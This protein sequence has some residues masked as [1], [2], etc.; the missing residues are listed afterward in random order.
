MQA[1][2]YSR[3]H[4]SELDIDG[5]ELLPSDHDSP[6]M[7]HSILIS[8]PQL[9]SLSYY[10]QRPASSSNL[11][12]SLKDFYRSA[13]STS[14]DSFGPCRRIEPR[15][16]CLPSSYLP[17]QVW[18]VSRNCRVWRTGILSIDWS[19]E[20]QKWASLT[21]RIRYSGL[22]ALDLSTA[23]PAAKH[24]RKR[25]SASQSDLASS[26][27][28]RQAFIWG[29]E[30]RLACS[31]LAGQL[32]QSWLQKLSTDSSWRKHLQSWFTWNSG[33]KSSWKG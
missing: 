10:L 2:R 18:C 30:W 21:Q 23:R 33:E 3:S 8:E 4:H 32:E 9:L 16:C 28:H 11:D 19:R 26:L 5:V 7:V 29:Y 15:V 31:L 27:N 6:N 12:S 24:K 13:T 17:Q 1:S 20:N 22:V 25:R 14:W